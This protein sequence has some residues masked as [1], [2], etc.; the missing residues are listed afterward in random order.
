VRTLGDPSE[1]I[2]GIS[3]GQITPVAHAPLLTSA[4]TAWSGFLLEKHAASAVRQDTIWGWHRTHVVLFTKGSL[5]FR[6]FT[7]G[8]TQHHRACLGSVS[9]FPGGFDETRFSVAGSDFE[10]ICLE[11]DPARVEALLGHHPNT[12]ADALAAQ[13]AIDDAQIAAL[14]S[15][16]A[17]EVEQGCS[18]GALYGQSLSLALA[19]Y[20]AG[21]FSPSPPET[22]PVRRLSRLQSQRLVDYVRANLDRELSLFELAALVQLS[23]R[24]FFR[25][26]ANT[27]DTTPHRYV[28]K[29]RVERAKMLLSGDDMLVDIANGLGFSNQ[30]HFSAVFRRA[31]GMSPGRY[32]KEHRS[33]IHAAVRSGTSLEDRDKIGQRL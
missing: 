20:L 5:G 33:P 21:R 19:A 28:I 16:M 23:P 3:E 31:T 11:L 12:S 1:R 26:F 32:R 8:G 4:H 9:I 7:A 22:K 25:T 14:L 13:I 27:F 10:A 17:L 2:T 24:Q 29:E 6:C 15:S 30:S 18:A